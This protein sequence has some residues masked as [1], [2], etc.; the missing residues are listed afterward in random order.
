MIVL[1]ASAA[2]LIF[3]FFNFLELGDVNGTSPGDL[4]DQCKSLPDDVPKAV[5]VVCDLAKHGGTSAWNT[6]LYF[7]LSAWPAIIAAVVLIVTALATFTQV[8]LPPRIVGFSPGELLFGLSVAATIVMFG[9]LI[10]S[11]LSED[12]DKGI[13]FWIAL[14]GSAAMAV[15]T[16]MELKDAGAGVARSGGNGAAP[17]PF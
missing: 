1:A 15:G 5:D 9:W 10:D 2:V 12:F 13:G 6:D 16:A 17:S 8:Q 11:N 14:L 3:S 7:P 4:K